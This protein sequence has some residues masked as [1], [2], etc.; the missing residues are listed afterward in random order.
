MDREDWAI[1]ATLVACLLFILLCLA[2]VVAGAK[3]W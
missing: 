1:A 3:G 2:M